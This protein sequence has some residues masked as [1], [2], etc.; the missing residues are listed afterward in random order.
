MVPDVQIDIPE[1]PG[2]ALGRV[3]LITD[4][5]INE[6]EAAFGNDQPGTTTTRRGLAARFVTTQVILAFHRTVDIYTRP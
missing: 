5:G 4:L 2:I 1:N 3:V 6:F